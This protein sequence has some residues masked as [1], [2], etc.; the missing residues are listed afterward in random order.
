MRTEK[1]IRKFM[2]DNR[3]PVPKND[4]F[5]SELIRQIDLLPQP[6]ALNDSEE[7]L[8]RQNRLLVEAIR[9]YMRKYLH[10]KAIT[11]LLVNA[12][13]CIGILLTVFLI[14]SESSDQS[15]L[16]NFIREWR[17]MVMCALCLCS[18]AISLHLTELGRQ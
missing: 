6:A 8:L 13:I 7:E 2:K 15:P 4:R 12:V 5:M 14:T 18:L 3:I 9:S 17:Y 1:E 10:R 16:L 11:T